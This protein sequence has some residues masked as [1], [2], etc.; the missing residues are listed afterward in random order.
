MAICR[1][2]VNLIE[3][4]SS[5]EFG[6]SIL[7]L[8]FLFALLE[9]FIIHV[10]HHDIIRIFLWHNNITSIQFHFCSYH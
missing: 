7:T 1:V 8:T 5:Y 4:T 3:D 9:T 2:N 10:V 6:K